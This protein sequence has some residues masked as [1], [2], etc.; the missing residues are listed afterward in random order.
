M[1]VELVDMTVWVATGESDWEDAL[2]D[3]PL[4]M[5]YWICF[6]S[7]ALFMQDAA[8]IWERFHAVNQVIV[9]A[10]PRPGERGES[11]GYNQNYCSWILLD[12]FC[13]TRSSPAPGNTMQSSTKRL[14][15]ITIAKLKPTSHS[16]NVSH[17]KNIA[18]VTARRGSDV[19]PDLGVPRLALAHHLLCQAMDTASKRYGLALLAD[20]TALLLNLVFTSYFFLERLLPFSP[21]RITFTGIMECVFAV[22]HLTRIFMLVQAPTHAIREV[23]PT[24]VIVSHTWYHLNRLCLDG[25]RLMITSVRLPERVKNTVN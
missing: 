22:M 16:L 12:A 21:L 23:M 15:T 10:T 19:E 7:E 11:R 9:A 3:M 2:V 25:E 14:E 1:S 5:T 4:Y 6:V 17:A 13:Q 20:M 8:A 18:V 24:P